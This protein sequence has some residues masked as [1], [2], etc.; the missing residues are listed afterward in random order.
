MTERRE[1]IGAVSYTVVLRGYVTGQLALPGYSLC[2]QGTQISVCSF[3]FE[4][5]PESDGTPLEF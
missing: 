3:G 2:V 1:V 4:L 5:V